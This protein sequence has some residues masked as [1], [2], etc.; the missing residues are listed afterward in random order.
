MKNRITM[1]IYVAVFFCL[2]VA[3]DGVLAQIKVSSETPIK[4]P[5]GRELQGNTG[6]PLE[7]DVPILC[8]YLKLMDPPT[9]ISAGAFGKISNF[10]I[11]PN[12]NHRLS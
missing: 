11:D 12:L 4:R 8:N 9:Q 2:S 10:R 6:T 5:K 7:N 3:G 1:V